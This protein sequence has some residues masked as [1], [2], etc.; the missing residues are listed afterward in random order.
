MLQAVYCAHA[1]DSN[2]FH[3]LYYA[4]ENCKLFGN[5]NSGVIVEPVLQDSVER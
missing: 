5:K 4:V 1:V 2:T 3:S